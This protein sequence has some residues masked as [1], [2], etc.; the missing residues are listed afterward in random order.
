MDFSNLRDIFEPHLEKIRE[1]ISFSDELGIVH[2]NSQI[3]RLVMQ[4]HP[5]FAI[6]DYR[7]G[8]IMRG[9]LRVVFNLVAKKLEE[10][11]LVFLGPGTIIT[12]LWLSDDLEIF[13]MA[14]FST[15]AMPF[16]SDQLPSA[17]NGQV[18]DFQI[19]ADKTDLETAKNIFNA[20]WQLVRTSNCNKK[21]RDSLIAALMHHYN[22]LYHRYSE[23][24]DMAKHRNQTI[25]DRFLYLVNTHAVKEH[26]LSFYASKMCLTERYL[27]TIIRQESGVTAKEWIDRAI[28]LRIK[29]EL[30][31]TDK[32]ILQISDDLNFPNASFFSKYFKR[33][34]GM[35]PAEYRQK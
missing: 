29:V 20:L 22:S 11:T 34:T 31:H 8:I 12:P 25:I 4:Q 32:T 23:L 3:F 7:F 17:F 24:Q 21:T 15:Y 19:K 30:K 2:A 33:L 5:P 26:R 28:I 1:Q 35:T 9:S 13:G 14:L 16:S 18:R 6:D 27:G 10:G